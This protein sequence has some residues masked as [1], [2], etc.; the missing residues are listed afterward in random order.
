MLQMKEER[1]W[2][3]QKRHWH[4]L[5]PVDKHAAGM[6]KSIALWKDAKQAQVIAKAET[7]TA[8]INLDVGRTTLVAKQ[9]G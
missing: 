6:P 2:G 9:S 7:W 8:E 3:V 1:F 5:W 4:L